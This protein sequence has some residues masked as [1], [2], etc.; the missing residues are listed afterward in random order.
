VP[1]A[2]AR[3]SN[4]VDLMERLRRSLEGS[5]GRAAAGRGRHEGSEK[6]PRKS[7]TRKA[8]SRKRQARR[9]A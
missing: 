2:P 9:V 6:S 1:D 7:R 8:G 5:A 3:D 4:V